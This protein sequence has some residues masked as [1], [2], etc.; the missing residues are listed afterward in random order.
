MKIQGPEIFIDFPCPFTGAVEAVPLQ[1]EK[2]IE[3]ARFEKLKH[4][5]TSHLRYSI[6][7]G[8]RY[9]HFRERKMKELIVQL[10]QPTSYDL[11]VQKLLKF[12]EYLDGVQQFQDVMNYL[13]NKRA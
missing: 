4:Y 5:I 12:S 2:I 10:Y 9:G 11:L 7:P 3:A 6:L 1:V 8:H 13:K